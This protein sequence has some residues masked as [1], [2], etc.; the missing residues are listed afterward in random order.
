MAGKIFHFRGRGAGVGGHCDGAELDAGKPGQNSLDA[1]IQMDQHELARLD[2]AFGEAGGERADAIVKFAVG[3]DSRRR[4]ERRPD[5][6][7]MV[8]ARLGPHPQ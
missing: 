3:P 6:E 1:I 2:A 7:R 8:P 4:I 5:Q